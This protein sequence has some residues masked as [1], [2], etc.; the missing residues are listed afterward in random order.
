MAVRVQYLSSSKKATASPTGEAREMKYGDQSDNSYVGEVVKFINAHPA[1][2]DIEKR[3]LVNRIIQKPTQQEYVEA[4]K[5][6]DEEE[7]NSSTPVPQSSG[8]RDSSAMGLE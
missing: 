5:Q 1:M 4:G 2:S 8:Q 7:N 6:R 3:I